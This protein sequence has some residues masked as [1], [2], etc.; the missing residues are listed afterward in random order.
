MNS[1]FLFLKEKKAKYGCRISLE[2]FG[3]YEN[4]KIYPLYAI[5]NILA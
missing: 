5:A 2:N 1:M 3:G 4:I